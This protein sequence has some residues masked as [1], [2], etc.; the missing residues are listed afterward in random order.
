MSSNEGQTG[1]ESIRLGGMSIDELPIREAALTKE[2]LPAV[3]ETIKRNKLGNIIAKYPKQTVDWVNGAIRECHATIKNV[4]N[5]MTRQQTMIDE[6][7]VHITL[8]DF[9]DSEIKNLDKD[10]PDYNE[11][12]R[13]LRLKF[14]P[15]QVPAMKQQIVQCKEAIERSNEVIDKEHASIAELNALLV[16]C[17]QRDEELKPFGIKGQ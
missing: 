4:R 11:K 17:K 8:C 1:F 6:Y 10:D 15:Y 12:L 13:D 2:Q 14:P 16:K 5:L 3:H 7:T 9:R